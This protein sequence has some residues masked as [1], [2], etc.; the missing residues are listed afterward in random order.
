MGGG[1][2]AEIAGAVVEAEIH[3]DEDRLQVKNVYSN[4]EVE[5]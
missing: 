1:Y 2:V 3:V 4:K 5:I